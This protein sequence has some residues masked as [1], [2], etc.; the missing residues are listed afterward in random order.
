MVHKKKWVYPFANFFKSRF[1][2]KGVQQTD[3]IRPATVINK[4]YAAAGRGKASY[5]GALREGKGT[6]AGEA[7]DG[8]EGNKE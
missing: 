2:V 7:G 6:N 1:P 3:N 8:Q 4:I 5:Q